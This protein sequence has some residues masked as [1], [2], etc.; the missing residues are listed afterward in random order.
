MGLF[1]RLFGRDKI[2]PNGLNEIYYRNSKIHQRYYK[3]NNSISGVCDQFYKNG[4]L[5]SKLNYKNGGIGLPY[6]E[7]YK[8]GQLKLE[9]YRNWEAMGHQ[10]W[11]EN[12]CVKKVMVG[13]TTESEPPNS[14]THYY[15]GVYMT[16]DIYDR[17]ISEKREVSVCFD[18]SRYLGDSP[19]L[20]EGWLNNSIISVAKEI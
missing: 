14:Y 8:N 5:M 6:K 20:S 11:Y 19:T 7:W 3:T 18:S 12:G 9:I 2:N 4:Q 1:G 10:E 16:Y 13:F 15:T 17:K